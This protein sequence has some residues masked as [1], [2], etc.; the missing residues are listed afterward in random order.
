MTILISSHLLGEVEKMVS[1]V[2]II[3]K[4]KMLFQGSLSNLH[5]FQQKGSRLFINTSDNETACKLLQ[6]QHPQKDEENLSVAFHDIT[7]VA[8]INRTLTRHGLDVYL[9]HPKK[10][11]LEQ[12]FIDLTSSQS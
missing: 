8:G 1:H 5:L 3:L 7:Q 9:L 4:G 11:D 10:T 6:D 2:G 12:L